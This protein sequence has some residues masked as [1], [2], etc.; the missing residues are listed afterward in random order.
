MKL[1]NKINMYT[2]FLFAVLL[3]LMNI[4]VYFTFNKLILTSE[5]STAQK[6]MVKITKNVG[7][8]VGLLPESELLRAYLPIS[9]MIR[10]VT[11]EQKPTTTVTSSSQQKLTQQK[12]IYYEGEISKSVV[13]E[14][15]HYAFLSMPIVMADGSIANLQVTKSM[16]TAIDNLNVLRFVL[17]AVTF[18]AL[19]PV[20][21]STRFL[22]NL[23]GLPVIKM[24]TTM[25][26]IKQSGRF[27]RLTLEDKSKDELFL[28]GETFNHMIDLLE[29][30][31]DK[32]QQF[33]SNA[34][35][36]LKTPLTIIESYASLIERRGLTEP[37]LFNESIFA[38]LSET[39]RM[40]E[41]TEQLLMLA[42][43][44]E[45][46]NIQI[47]QVNLVD[48]IQETV[49]SFRNA[50]NRDI[51]F[52]MGVESIFVETDKKKLK[53]LMFIFLDNAMKYSDYT[54]TVLI[55]IQDCHSFIKIVDQGIG[56]P[57]DELAKVFDRFYRVDK[58]RSRKKGGSGLG[59]SLAKEMA[60]ALGVSIS[61]ESVESVETIA[62]IYIPLS[63]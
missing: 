48:L 17:I 62:T 58:A 31:F 1:R 60:E 50:Y 7:K 59:L 37:D 13:Y 43:H 39:Q 12:A 4:A 6:E 14:K 56:I 19:I 29:M 57:K 36:E 38:I 26:R 55:G 33:V 18:L 32:Q 9:G 41:M 51:N 27:Q 35:H 2:A 54:I 15:Q 30:N 23:I 5:L 16:E 10:I 21:I 8:S 42:K 63:K 61:L 34:S 40:K 3:I 52:A 46:W 47:T 44:N 49:K 20:F 11:E 22:S 24:I 45:H 28:M 25:T 53:Q